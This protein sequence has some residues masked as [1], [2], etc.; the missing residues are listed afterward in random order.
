MTPDDFKRAWEEGGDQLVT[1]A[2]GVVATLG[3]PEAQRA[4]LIQ[5]GLPE[6]AAPYLDFGGKYY[7]AI[8]SAAEL[9]KAGEA[10]RRYRVIGANGFGDPICVDEEAGGAVVYLRHD[11]E[12]KSHFMNSNLECLA[13]SLLAFR[14]VVRQSQQR[15]GPDAYLDGQI[16][17]DVVDQFIVRIDE[18]DPP[19]IRSDAFWFRS[20]MG[21]G[22]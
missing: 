16:P 19:A 10:F 22:I 20:I 14:E 21:E 7:N 11:D 12:M 13:G 2:P 15:G 3:I 4:F 9:W 6:S 1:F 17:S 5:P 8:P 18:I